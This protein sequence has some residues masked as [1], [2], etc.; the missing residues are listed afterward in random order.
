MDDENPYAPPKYAQLDR[1]L[2]GEHPNAAWRDGRLLMARKGA[3]LP[4]RCLK[5]NAP[6]EGRPFK[7]SLS[8]ASPYWALSIFLIG[9]ILFIVVYTI[10]SRRGKVSVSLCP[11]HRM[12]RLRAI[13]LGWL[14]ALAG[15]G[16]MIATGVASDYITPF[17][18]S[19]NL[20]LSIGIGFGIVLILAG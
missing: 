5:C 9:P 8:W 14:A 7:R 10:V 3:V 11:R 4:D 13:A 6:A 15:I 18:I 16:C 20:F 1:D 12:E 19:L 17:G 2:V